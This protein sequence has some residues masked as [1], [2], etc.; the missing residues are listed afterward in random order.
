MTLKK[1]FI[2]GAALFILGCGDDAGDD[3][4]DGSADA[5]SVF[6]LVNAER[7]DVGLPRYV[8][9]TYLGTA[10]LDHARDMSDNNYFDHRSLDGRSFS[11]RVD[12]TEYDGFATGENI[13][14][15]QQN[16]DQVMKSWM[17]S[18]GHKRNILDNNSTK[19]G[20]GFFGGYWVQ[21]FGR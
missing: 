4:C 11:D 1:L 5:C 16:A 3:G 19:I 20:V 14:Q 12:E 17:G 2:L 13:A 8:W 18:V 21:V 15:G 7:S 6:A 9:D 10:A